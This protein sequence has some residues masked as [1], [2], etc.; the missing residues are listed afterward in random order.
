MTVSRE[1]AISGEGQVRGFFSGAMGAGPTKGA[2]T[3]YVAVMADSARRE[4]EKEAR[5]GAGAGAGATETAT[6][7][8]GCFWGVELAF[9]RIPGVLSTQVGYAGGSVENP[10]YEQVCAGSTGHT[11]AVRIEFDPEVVRYGE[12]LRVFFERHDPAD[13]GGQGNDRGTQ[14]RSAVFT[15][16][17]EQRK[18]LAE[19]VGEVEKQ[20]GGAVATQRLDAAEHAFWPAEPYHQVRAARSA[21]L[22]AATLTPPRLWLDV[23]PAVVRVCLA[24]NTWRRAGRWRPRAPR[25]PFVATA[26]MHVACKQ[27]ASRLHGP[28]T[29]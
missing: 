12:L 28:F 21:L 29:Q 2:G 9:Q 17:D 16:S 15:H 7:A 6:L 19:V 24:S 26:R 20:L 23:V 4:R 1:A 5:G 22:P 11:E 25:T 3:A 27:S 14:Y 13:A 8:A 10:T 18:A